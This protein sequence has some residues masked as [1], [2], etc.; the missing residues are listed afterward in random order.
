MEMIEG[1]NG[2]EILLCAALL[3]PVLQSIAIYH[4]I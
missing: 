2:E 1:T 3:D 4:L